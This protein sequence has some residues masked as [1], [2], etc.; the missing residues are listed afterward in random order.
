ML[1]SNKK[2]YIYIYTYIH[3][4]LNMHTLQHCIIIAVMIYFVKHGLT[5]NAFV[6]LVEG[7]EANPRI[8]V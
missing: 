7:Y 1:R 8:V 2:T 5:Y 4:L 6:K 3:T